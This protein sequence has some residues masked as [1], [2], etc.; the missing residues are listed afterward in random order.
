MVITYVTIS[1][2]L[3]LHEYIPSGLRKISYFVGR[4]TFPILLF[5][6]IFTI[7][8]RLFIPLFL[9][10][11]SGIC[12]MCVAVCFVV[13]GCLL[14]AR[15]ADKIGLSRFLVGKECLLNTDLSH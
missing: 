3:F 13:L 11:T 9:F 2:L 6:P 7:L 12:F 1:F 5:S 8:S 15:L 4:N 14:L 10:D